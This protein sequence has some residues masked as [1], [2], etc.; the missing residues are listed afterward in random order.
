M[1]LILSTCNA[2]NG[3]YNVFE[4]ALAIS[5]ESYTL[6]LHILVEGSQTMEP[7]IS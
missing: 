2:L 7:S 3:I 6:D 1:L 5:Y 4:G